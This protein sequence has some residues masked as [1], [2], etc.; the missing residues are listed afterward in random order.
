MKLDYL[1]ICEICNKEYHPSSYSQKFCNTCSTKNCIVCG[2]Q[3]SAKGKFV[4]IQE[5]QY[6][7]RKCYLQTRWGA[8]KCKFCG[9]K[10]KT[11][12]CS[13]KCRNDYWNKNDYHLQKKPLFWKKKKEIINELGGKCKKCG[14]SDIRVL[15]IN[16]IDRNKKERPPKLNYTN[17]NRLSEWRRNMNNLEL[18]C[19]NCHRIHT[20]KQMGYGNFNTKP[21]Q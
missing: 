19:A 18:L 13:D 9:G 6:C 16:H 14:I 10:S 11:T 1:K 8:E 3:Y 21:S 15:E 12:Y 2:K 20:Y 17:G 7:S 4:T 5:S